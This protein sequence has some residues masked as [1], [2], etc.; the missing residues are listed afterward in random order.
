[1]GEDDNAGSTIFPQLAK[2]ALQLH[3]QGEYERRIKLPDGV[4]IKAEDLPPDCRFNDDELEFTTIAA[5]NE[6]VAKGVL[7]QLSPNAE[8]NE[9][10]NAAYKLWGHEIGHADQASGRLLALVAGRLDILAAGTQRIRSGARIY[11]V[12]HLIE[13]TV[14]YLNTIDAKSI[15]DL[16]NA[17]HGPT[18]IDMAGNPV[19]GVLETWLDAKPNQALALHAQV[20][21]HLN[22]E[23]KVLLVI[24]ILAL[25]KSDYTK[26]VEVAREDGNSQVQLRAEASMWAFGR[27]LLVDQAPQELIKGVE[28]AVIEVINGNRGELKFHA[29][30]AAT[31]AMHT[32]V[33]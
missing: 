9:L 8:A 11:D 32:H 30:S 14:P 33:R 22:D 7:E 4:T 29:L 20:L 16:A 24:A 10:F 23:T 28:E 15:I 26:A 3:Q 31:G 5:R 17:S 13:A 2:L 6:A 25:S 1:M 27:L 12:L 19:Y 21:E 18:K